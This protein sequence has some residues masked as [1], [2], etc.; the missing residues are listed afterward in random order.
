VPYLGGGVTI[1]SAVYCFGKMKRDIEQNKE[2]L[3]RIAN[4][5]ERFI[6]LE[7]EHNLAMNGKLE[8]KHK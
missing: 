8:I 4:I 1:L 5:E 7:N 2:N 6:K 3:N